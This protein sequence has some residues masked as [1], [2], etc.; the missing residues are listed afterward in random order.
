[1]FPERMDKNKLWYSHTL[2][3][4][5]HEN[6]LELYAEKMDTCWEEKPIFGRLNN[7]VSFMFITV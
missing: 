1:M 3:L 7:V 5:N 4:H 6:K 2:A